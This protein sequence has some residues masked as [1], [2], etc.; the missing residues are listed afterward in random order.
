MSRL[1]SPEVLRGILE[2]LQTG[3]CIVD[4]SQKILFWND[5]AQRI[6]GFLRHEIVGQCRRS[7]LFAEGDA[8]SGIVA[9][10]AQ[11]IHQ[12]LSGGAAAVV[13]TAMRHK[14]GHPVVVRLWVTPI[15]NP[16]GLIIGAAESFHETFSDSD[17]DRRQNKL[18]AYGCQDPV[19]GAATRRFVQSQIQEHLCTF[20]EYQIPISLLCIEVDRI[21]ELLK[22][23]GARAI[24]VILRV[25]A[26]TLG[27]HL[28][29]T[30]L[31]GYLGE[32]RFLAVISGCGAEGL[33]T[34][35]ER[36]RGLVTRAR[37]NWWGDSLP[38]SASFGGAYAAP[39][40]TVESLMER[41]QLALEAGLASGG[42]CVR[43]L[44]P[45]SC[46]P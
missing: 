18:A 42:N 23:R 27:N 17:W 24:A 35:A 43:V 46:D 4:P 28:A 40:D 29:P 12:A 14:D 2:G 30:C 22:S 1:E 13:Q 20:Q 11:A 45:E 15:R 6:T 3:I 34:E 33:T 38:L 36:L 21:Q 8:H 44:D 25:V 32:H 19:T 26:V 41:A 39:G 31:L 9:D 37:V 10:A 5:G 16:E 7:D